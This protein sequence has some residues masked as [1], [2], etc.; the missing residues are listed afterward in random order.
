MK[1]INP[2][3][4]NGECD[5][6]RDR[7]I[8]FQSFPGIKTFQL[9]DDA[10]PK[11]KSLTKQFHIKED[12]PMFYTLRLEELNCWQRVGIFLCINE[13]DGKG[14]KTENIVKVRACFADL[15]E[16]PIDPV[17]KYEPSM[18]IESSPGKYHAYWFSDNI[19]L[20][21]FQ[22][23]Q[24][25]II[26]KIGSDPQVKDLPRVMRVPGFYHQKDKRFLVRI[27]H[28]TG[29]KFDFALLTNRFPPKPKKKWSAP[30]YQQ[31]SNDQ[32]TEF[33]GQYGSSKGSRN[34][35][36]TKIIGGMIKTRRDWGYIESEVWKHNS[37]SHPPLS[38]S[39]VRAV[40]H[41]MKRY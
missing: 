7:R 27:I 14:R 39:E 3:S 1:L 20:E 31:Q 4:K 19:P 21:G 33:K 34:C 18:V 28:Y 10:D 13:T 40:L 8:F 37:C 41:S 29:L 12:M 15:D 24:E 16:V 25:G 9:L 5:F 26:E 17:L 2:K 36:L 6:E 38:E 30:K 32:G 22:Q 23:L 11:D 35:N